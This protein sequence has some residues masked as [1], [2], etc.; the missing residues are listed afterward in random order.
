ML[1]FLAS[2]LINLYEHHV[3]QTFYPIKTQ[4]FSHEKCNS[5][6]HNIYTVFKIQRWDIAYIFI[7]NY[8]RLGKVKILSYSGK[9]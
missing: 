9:M 3:S 6:I 5:Y 1:S 7:Q 2:I 8:N 4:M